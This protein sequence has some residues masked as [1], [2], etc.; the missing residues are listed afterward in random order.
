MDKAKKKQKENSYMLILVHFEKKV[1]ASFIE[2]YRETL[3]LKN[4][5]NSKAGDT[6]ERSS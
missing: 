4:Q 6:Y 5:E 3:V 1:F 2:S